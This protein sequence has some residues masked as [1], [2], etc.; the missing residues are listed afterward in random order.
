MECRDKV[1][2][3]DRLLLRILDESWAETVL[4]YYLRNFAFLRQWEPQR[5][6]EFFTAECQRSLLLTELAR[7]NLG[8]MFRFWIV[9]KEEARQRRTIGTVALSNIVRGGFQ[10]CHLGYKLDQSELR[11]GYMTE[12]IG[13]VV[14]FAF[15]ELG[16]HRVEANIL[17][18]NAASLGV[19]GKLGFYHEGLARKYLQI[20]GRW[21]DHIHMVIRNLAMEEIEN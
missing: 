15:G 2:E 3:T 12:A 18:R 13:G 21:E 7:M 17:P 4:D 5:D 6:A 1:I 14:G 16:L 10:S 20:N 8:E 11:R 9:K 19:V